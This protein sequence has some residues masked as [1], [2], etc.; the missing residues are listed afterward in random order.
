MTLAINEIVRPEGTGPAG[1]GKGIAW[2]GRHRILEIHP[3]VTFL[4]P[5][6]RPWRM[7]VVLDTRT[8]A[9]QLQRGVVIKEA[10]AETGYLRRPE[11]SIPATARQVRDE[12]V[13]ILGPLLKEDRWRLFDA[14]E[15]GRAVTERAAAAK[16]PRKSVYRMLYRYWANG[17]NEDALLPDWTTHGGPGKRRTRATRT[18]EGKARIGR[19]PS[20]AQVGAGG[21]VTNF[22]AS[23][24]DLQ[25]FRRAMD[26]YFEEAKGSLK[27]VYDLMTT[28]LYVKEHVMVDGQLVAQPLPLEEIPSFEM[29]RHAIAR[30]ADLHALHQKRVGERKFK[31][32]DRALSG[33]ARE[34]TRG[35]GERFQIDATLADI[36]AVH[37]LRRDWIIGR[38]VVYLVFD[39]FSTMIVGLFVGLWGPS[40]S[41]A[42]LALMN[43]FSNKVEYCR[44]FGITVTHEDWPCDIVC[45]TLHADRQELLSNA[46]SGLRR[47][48]SIDSQIAEAFRP[49]LKMIESRFHLLNRFTRIHWT[50]GAVVQRGKERD[51]ADKRLDAILDLE[52][53]TRILIRAILHYN[54]YQNCTQHRLSHPLLVTSDVEPTPIG[55]WNYASGRYMGTFRRESP[56]KLRRALLPTAKASVTERGIQFGDA[57]Y[58]TA[59]ALTQDWFSKARYRGRDRVE[60]AHDTDWRDQIWVRH[61]QSG[62]F[63]VAT[64]RSISG[65]YSSLR[66]EEMQDLAAMN[67]VVPSKLA[68]EA[69]RS[70]AQLD[71]HIQAEVGIAEGKR[72]AQRAAHGQPSNA[73]RIGAIRANRSA[74]AEEEKARLAQEAYAPASPPAAPAV[75][76]APDTQG[77][78]V[79]ASE[80]AYEQQH[81]ANVIDLMRR[82]RSLGRQE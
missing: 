59:S 17:Q 63:E 72:D 32:N 16:L 61:P 35:P 39:V 19:P 44:R 80:D 14:E 62:A 49:D 5:M 12:A 81:A 11:A 21:V 73:Q 9:E 58:E 2:T 29:F 50:P 7:Y 45:S 26:L 46:A 43:A 31:Q 56:D 10:M 22:N 76:A 42:R 24:H 48:L 79:A 33:S 36:Y 41:C 60:V 47:N 66:H 70:K 53:I 3:D 68:N 20:A 54:K 4:M 55:L 13:R 18:V 34:D 1:T 52:Q 51:S 57:L 15:R 82:K 74:A 30:D 38:P 27:G 67:A 23:E 71:S 37:K 75:Q 77:T 69:Q 40:W 64:L 65:I 78:Q 25:Q 6:A 8:L 28:R